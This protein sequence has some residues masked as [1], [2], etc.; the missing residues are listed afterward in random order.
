[1]FVEMGIL[2]ALF[3][4]RIRRDNLIELHIIFLLSDVMRLMRLFY[5]FTYPL[6]VPVCCYLCCY[7]PVVYPLIY[8][9]DVLFFRGYV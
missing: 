4:S 7:L 3:C 2:S 1:M 8:L 6:D 5:P 9:L